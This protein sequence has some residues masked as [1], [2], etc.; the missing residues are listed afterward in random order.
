MARV[1]KPERK[2]DASR[3]Q[4]QARETRLRIIRAAHRL[5]VEQGYGRTTMANIA[6]AAG[7]S[8]ESVYASF[9][10]KA[11]LLHRA[12]DI[13]IGGDD[14]EIAF[15][16]R[17]EVLAVRNEPDLATRFMLHARLSTQT[18]RRMTPF[19]RAVQAAAGTEPAAAAM[20]EEI[21]RQRLMGMTVMAAEAAKTGQL[22]VTEEEC[23]DVIWAFTEGAMWHQMV[24]ER[25]WSDDRFAEW[26]GTIWVRMLVAT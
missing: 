17:P 12:W 9:K 22:A 26:L 4:E 7:V 21:N 1:V 25:G 16:D 23:R 3:R 13:T 18:A 15:H 11:T 5:F 20:I 2:Y 24:N 8:V 10:N 14:E 19:I 6:D